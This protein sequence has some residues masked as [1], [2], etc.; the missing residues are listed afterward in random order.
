M[1]QIRDLPILPDV[2]KS[3]LVEPLSRSRAGKLRRFS[4]YGIE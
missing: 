2:G 3:K 1:D 4:R